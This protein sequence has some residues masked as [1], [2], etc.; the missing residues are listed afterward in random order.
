MMY[1]LL[2]VVCLTALFAIRAKA[3]TE[4]PRLLVYDGAILVG[5]VN[6]GGFINCTGPN[7]NVSKG[8]KRL[9][10]GMLPSLRFKED[11]SVPKN[12]LFVPTLG[13]GVTF[14]YKA[15][16]LQLPAYYNAKTAAS[17]GSWHLGIGIGLR[18]NHFNN[19][20]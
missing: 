11:R 2:F 18:L 3:Q 15:L 7:I 5:Y 12:A 19:K 14:C 20:P 17:D 1:R 16:A 6:N 10:I 13:V 4:Q 9:M 8:N